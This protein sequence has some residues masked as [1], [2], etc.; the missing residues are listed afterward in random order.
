MILRRTKIFFVPLHFWTPISKW[1]F[2]LLRPLS[3]GLYIWIY[4]FSSFGSYC[5]DR[6]CTIISEKNRTA[7]ILGLSIIGTVTITEIATS[8]LF[9]S[10]RI[11]EATL[12]DDFS[13]IHLILRKNEKFEVRS[14]YFYGPDKIFNGTYEIQNSKIIFK[15]KPYNN[16]FI[17]DTVFIYEDKIYLRRNNN[18]S[19]TLNLENI[20]K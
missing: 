14:T 7:L 3:P 18:G 8:E 16:D 17:P 5:S 19:L 12:V 6:N 1:L 13:S 10:E 11:L 9:K 15:E 4:F 2:F 20:F